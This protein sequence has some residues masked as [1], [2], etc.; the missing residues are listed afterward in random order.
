MDL[1]KTQK[2]FHAVVVLGMAATL[3]ACS[4]SNEPSDG[5]SD[6]GQ[7][8]NDANTVKDVATADV[9]TPVDAGGDGFS[10]WLGC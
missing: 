1:S 7:Q 6:S 10:G 2:L 4:S 5:G 3:G 9:S 8:A